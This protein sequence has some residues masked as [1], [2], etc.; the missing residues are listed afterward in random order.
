MPGLEQNNQ[1]KNQVTGNNGQGANASRSTLGGPRKA[2]VQGGLR[3]NDPNR[4]QEPQGGIRGNRSPQT[5]GGMRQRTAGPRNAKS[6]NDTVLNETVTEKAKSTVEEPKKVL[7]EAEKTATVQAEKEVKAKEVKEVKENKEAKEVKT[8]SEVKV[9]KKEENTVKAA[10]K[11]VVK[12]KTV[13]AVKEEKTEKPLDKGFTGL[14]LDQLGAS[15]QNTSV[16]GRKVTVNT[17]KPASSEKKEFVKGEKRTF[18]SNRDRNDRNDKN[19]RNDRN[20]RFSK[21]NNGKASGNGEHRDNNF[22]D[23][24]NKKFSGPKNNDGFNK[25]FNKDRKPA[26]NDEA[27]KKFDDDDDDKRGSRGRAVQKSKPSAVPVGTDKAVDSRNARLSNKN[28]DKA[29]SFNDYDDENDSKKGGKKGKVIGKTTFIKTVVKPVEKP[30]ITEISIGDVVSA[31][32]LID[33]MQI[34][35]TDF[36]KRLWGYENGAKYNMFNTNINTEFTYDE[37]EE[38]VITLFDILVSKEKSEIEKLI[39]DIP[40]EDENAIERPPVVC[41][42]GHVDHGKTSLLDTIRKTH[43]TA[44]E[45]GGITQH[46]GAYMVEINGKKITFLDT[47]G[48]EAFTAMRLRGA[49]ATDIAVLVV[50]ADDGV[51]PQTIEAINHAKAAKVPIIVA[52]NKIDKPAANI[53][54]LMNEMSEQEIVPQEWGGDYEFVPVSAKVGTGI[55]DLLETIL[56]IAELQELKADVDRKARGVV[57]EAKLDKGRGP[58]ATVLVQ[59]G[60]LKQGDFVAIGSVYGKVRTMT[61]CTGKTV[62]SAT[63]STPVEILGLKSVPEAGEIIIATK[64]EKEAK[65]IADAYQNQH[66]KKLLAETKNKISM[67]NIDALIQAGELKDLNIIVKADVQGSVEAVSKSLRDLSNDEVN[68]KVI[69]SAAGLIKEGDVALAS[70]SNAII[71]GFNVKADNSAK[72]SAEREGVEIKYY[73]VIYDAINEVENAMKGMLAPVFEEK[74]IG[75][76]EIRALF[77][78][79]KVGVIAGSYITDGK[80]TRNAKARITRDGQ[81]IFDGNV[82]SLKR[83]KDDAKEVAKGFECG[84]LFD[85]FNDIKEGDI[86]EFYVLEEVKR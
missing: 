79:S 81:E 55:D 83:E 13:E 64:T 8:A 72:E 45:A 44:R 36:F 40:A 23:R 50:A 16:T 86:A 28:R 1:K 32:E 19:E 48:H 42:M 2:P 65:E 41:V 10:E 52:M 58:M 46:I 31:R 66:R 73:N 60:T 54:R 69:H 29:K 82:A 7:K 9:P 76:C 85:K 22:R 11:E 43:V 27:G 59:K 26:F 62:K 51:M 71:I 70:A 80:V 39:E 12:E 6:E 84:I 49:M 67:S 75:H 74:V 37:A 17:E 18:G 30:V 57:I 14:T 4:K 38:M 35:Q 5:L 47:P 33:K 56:T 20:D 61:D 15:L 78:A 25:P 24:D 34:N 21:N 63:P 3:T 77:K 53:Q 68:V